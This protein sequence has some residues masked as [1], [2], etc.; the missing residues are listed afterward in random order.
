M[1]TDQTYQ[2]LAQLKLQ[3]MAARYAA[4]A[5][6][7]VHQQPEGHAMVAMLVEAE[8]EQRI[9]YRTQLYLKLA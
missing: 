1:N 5:E 6:Q 4:I 3:G 9:L 2:Q 7:P 8:Q